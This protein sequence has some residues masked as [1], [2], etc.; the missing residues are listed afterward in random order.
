MNFD[1]LNSNFG[2]DHDFIRDILQ[3]MVPDIDAKLTDLRTYISINDSENCH[4]IIHNIKYGIEM[5]GL[6]DMLARLKEID[7]HAK[8]GNDLIP[9]QAEV[10]SLESEWKSIR[11]DILDHYK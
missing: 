10:E 8:C 9:Y 11:Q 2:D 4:R 3:N 6:A 1:Y 5:L 7:H